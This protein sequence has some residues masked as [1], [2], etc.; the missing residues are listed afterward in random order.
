M[1]ISALGFMGCKQ[2]AASRPLFHT[3]QLWHSGFDTFALAG[4]RDS[5][6]QRWSTLQLFIEFKTLRSECMIAKAIKNKCVF[7]LNQKRSDRFAHFAGF[8]QLPCFFSS[9]AQQSPPVAAQELTCVFKAGYLEKRRKGRF[10]PHTCASVLQFAL[11]INQSISCYRL[12]LLL[13]FSWQITAF[14]AQSGRRDGAL[15]ATTSSTIT[16]VKKVQPV[17]SSLCVCVFSGSF[18]HSLKTS[19][20]S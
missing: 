7:C 3:K 18:N 13:V 1:V 17:W 8:P 16:A 2:L 9:G 11:M 4:W 19:L 5:P 6:P 20:F 10:L 14:L 15:W 12:R